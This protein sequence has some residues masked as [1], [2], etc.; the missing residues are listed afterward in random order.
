MIRLLLFLEVQACLITTINTPNSTNVIAK[1]SMA[2]STW[3]T[4]KGENNECILRLSTGAEEAI[5]LMF[6]LVTLERNLFLSLNNY[7]KLTLM[8]LLLRV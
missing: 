3:T 7:F 5:Y 2:F 8:P 6:L 4:V 1:L